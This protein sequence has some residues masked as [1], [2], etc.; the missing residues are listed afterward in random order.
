MTPCIPRL[1]SNNIRLE[2][3]SCLS[4]TSS[5]GDRRNCL[6][7]WIYYV[8]LKNRRAYNALWLTLGEAGSCCIGLE[9]DTIGIGCLIPKDEK[10][11]AKF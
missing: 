7:W 10:D 4:I 3:I 9:G 11:D 8:D 2:S 1:T 6:Y 5:V